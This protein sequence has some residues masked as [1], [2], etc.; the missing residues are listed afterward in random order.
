MPGREAHRINTWQTDYVTED[1]SSL[2]SARNSRAVP[3]VAV[4]VVI[5]GMESYATDGVTNVEH[6]LPVTPDTLF[7][8]GSASKTFTATAVMALVERDGL[9]LNDR[10]APLLPEYD[11]GDAASGLVVEHL[12]SHRGG[13]QGDWALFNAPASRDP[14][15][16]AELVSQAS[17]VP[18][19]GPPGG[20]FS[21]DNFGWC[22]LGAL[23]ESVTGLNF[24]AAMAEL[25]LRP[26]GLHSTTFWADEAIT[27]RVSAGHS[28]AEDGTT[29]VARGTEPWADRWPCRRALWPTGGVVSSVSDLLTWAR[30]HLTGE[31]V[32]GGSSPLSKQCR[33]AM[34]EPLVPSGGQGLAAG[35]G[36]HLRYA[37]GLVLL[38]HTGAGQG[39]F[40]QVVVVPARRS[41]MVALTNSSAGPD[42]VESVYDWYL[43][44]LGTRPDA[45]E[46]VIPRLNPAALEG[47]YRAVTRDLVLSEAT[48]RTVRVEVVDSGPTWH[49]TTTSVLAFAGEDA[50]V[51][52]DEPDL[53][54]QFGS[55]ADGTQWI[56]YRGRVHI[57]G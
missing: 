25:V 35:L 9:A 39:F 11:L 10:V 17:S 32:T 27:H 29:L 31:V 52:V 37:S 50:L 48:D 41:V 33:L 23:I 1:L 55:L 24:D 18:R 6:P 22:V 28:V 12:L 19:C 57:K 36:W 44:A 43:E 3:G 15:A 45:I 2:V 20:P 40:A 38:S 42:F 47:T 4:G 46:Y 16:L 54:M 7:Q 8:V 26:L 34:Q 5:D 49:G 30:F 51:G 13:W 56:R 21:Y 14:T 53:R